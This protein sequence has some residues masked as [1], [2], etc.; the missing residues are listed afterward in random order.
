MSCPLLVVLKGSSELLLP[1]GKVAKVIKVVTAAVLA[2]V[3]P[4]DTVA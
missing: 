4:P 2:V 3:L 1:P